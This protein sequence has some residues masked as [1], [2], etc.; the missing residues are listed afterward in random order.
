[1]SISSNGVAGDVNTLLR[2]LMPTLDK[3]GYAEQPSQAE[4]M[5]AAER[6]A[7]AAHRKLMAGCVGADVRRAWP[8]HKPGYSKLVAKGP[9]KQ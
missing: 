4:A 5:R 1:M 7:D 3:Y 8:K 6:L 2:Y 9:A